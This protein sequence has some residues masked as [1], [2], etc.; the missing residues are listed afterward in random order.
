MRT[1]VG[2]LSEPIGAVPAPPGGPLM[3]ISTTVP[4]DRVDA[5]G[6]FWHSEAVGDVGRALERAGFDGV[7]VT[8]HPVPS[9]R[10]L[11]AGGH[12]AQD[13]FVML[14]FLGAATTTL[15]LQT[16]ILVLPY[17]N[18]FLTARAVSTL[19]QLTHGRV[20]LGVG[21]GYMKGE[22]RALGVDFE[23]RND[24]TDE[25]LRALKVAWTAG[26]F[27][28]AGTGYSA[29][30]SRILPRPFRR[31]HPPLLIG[32]N[33]QRAIRRAVELGDAWSPFFTTDAVSTAARTAELAGVAALAEG[34]AYLR[35]RSERVGRE[36]PP[37]I[38]VAGLTA[39]H[40]P[41]D[42]AELLDR[43]ARLGEIGV[44]GVAVQLSGRDLPE[45]Y[46]EVV[47]FGEEVIAPLH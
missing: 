3:K 24:L 11:D 34:I 4:F 23:Q 21:A 8:D 31:P 41:W 17:R 19:D 6:E 1:A 2:S 46:D 9:G 18:P 10:W 5:D 42:A 20:L 7:T 12:H 47:R 14:S 43:I 25:Y 27:S 28:F 40:E 35:D 44:T 26:E 33:S 45:Y 32:G 36:T 22:Y 15:E 16:G 30:R 13:P 37:E 39:P 29:S 38:S